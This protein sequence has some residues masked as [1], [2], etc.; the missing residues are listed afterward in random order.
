MTQYY[1]QR[2]NAMPLTAN[3]TSLST[4]KGN[5]I[6]HQKN[7]NNYKTDT[8]YVAEQQK[9]LDETKKLM[10]WWKLKNLSLGKPIGRKDIRLI[11]PV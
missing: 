11:R 5:K 9:E 3:G 8:K 2:E 1:A 7:I 10:P 4:L 6:V